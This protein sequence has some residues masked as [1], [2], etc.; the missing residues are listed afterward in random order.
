MDERRQL[1][2]WE[3]KKEAKVWIQQTQDFRHCTIED[4]HLKGMCISIDKQLPWQDPVK[5]SFTMGD[6]MEFIKVEALVPWAKEDRGWYTYGLSFTRI[7]DADKDKIFEYL[8]NN[9]YD[10]IKSKWWA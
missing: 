5:I 10:Q 8:N 4:L 2:R 9:C 7:E 6:S 3:I 1:P